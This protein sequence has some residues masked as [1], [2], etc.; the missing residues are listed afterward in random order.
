MNFDLN[1]YIHRIIA[2]VESKGICPCR[3]HVFTHSNGKHSTL[4]LIY[5][6]AEKTTIEFTYS[7]KT[8][9][10]CILLNIK[11]DLLEGCLAE[12]MTFNCAYYSNIDESLSC[13]ELIT[14][15][16]VYQFVSE[17]WRRLSDNT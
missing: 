3:Y 17:Q 12:E 15:K 7:T 1:G 14:Q 9:E 8:K 5:Q 16:D 10:G 4:H 11:S 2:N 13:D 6:L